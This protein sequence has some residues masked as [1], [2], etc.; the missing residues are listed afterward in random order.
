MPTTPIPLA[1]VRSIVAVAIVVLT[2]IYASAAPTQADEEMIDHRL[3][4]LTTEAMREGAEYY[5][6]MDAAFGVVYEPE[7]AGLIENV[8]AYRLPTTFVLFAALP[9]DRIIWFVFA[10][11]AAL[12]GIV[13]SH[14]STRPIV[15]I[16]VTVYLLAIGVLNERGVW[17]DQFMTT[18]LWA[19]APLVGAVLASMRQRWWLAAGLA[20]FAFSVRETAGLLLV[21][22]VLAAA[23]A[24]VPRMPWFTAGAAAVAGY[25]AHAAAVQPYIEPGVGYG[26]LLEGLSPGAIVAIAGFGLPVG[27]VLGPILWAVALSHVWKRAEPRLLLAAPLVLPLAG[28]MIDRQYWGI[29]VVP[30]TVV[31]GTEGLLEFR[32]SHRAPERTEGVT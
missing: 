13:A 16:L 22:G 28:L 17:V 5:E 12:A 11:V 6:A 18:E 2:V 14:I 3:F 7:R 30:L 10:G 29:L 23:F 25:V 4:R 1:H 31:W 19:V 21:A 9:N 24:V 8:R 26:I 15:G 27:L 20:L 32:E